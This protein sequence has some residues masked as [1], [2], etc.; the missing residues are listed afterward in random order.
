MSKLTY[1]DDDWIN[2][3]LHPSWTCPRKV[4]DKNKAM[5]MKCRKTFSLSNRACQTVKSHEKSAKHIN[6]QINQQL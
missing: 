6:Q 2:P 1:F 3:D 4:E 5:C